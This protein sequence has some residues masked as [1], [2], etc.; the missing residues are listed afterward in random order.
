MASSDNRWLFSSFVL[1]VSFRKYQKYVVINCTTREFRPSSR[2]I[3]CGNQGGCN[4]FTIRPFRGRHVYV[5]RTLYGFFSSCWFQR[6]L[7][8]VDFYEYT[9][10]TF[11]CFHL[12]KFQRFKEP[13]RMEIG[14]GISNGEHLVQFGCS[15]T[16]IFQTS[17]II[18]P[19]QPQVINFTVPG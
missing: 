5:Y 4:S 15:Y 13:P 2:G 8:K 19:A 18:P 6:K 16:I 10:I 9:I 1:D 11:S 3:Q 17:P 7:S 12:C 14:S